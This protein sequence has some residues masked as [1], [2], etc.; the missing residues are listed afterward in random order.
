MV[1]SSETSASAYMPCT[2]AKAPPLKEMTV[3][4][5]SGVDRYETAVA[6]SRAGFNGPICFVYVAS[7][8]DFADALAGASRAAF[9]NTSPLLLVR[10]DHVPAAVRR[11][12]ARLDPVH[13]MV[14]GG[15][16]AISPAT[17]AQL[18]AIP[19]RGDVVLIDGP[20][21]YATAVAMAGVETRKPMFLASGQ[22]FP[23]ALSAASMVGASYG[24]LLLTPQ[25]ALPSV[26][27]HAVVEK[28]P[29]SITVLG[30][31]GAVSD[32]VVRDL[33][34][35]SGRTVSRIAGADRYET[36]VAVSRAY[37]SFTERVYI[38]SGATF[39]DALGVAP[40]ARLSRSAVL[41]VEPNRIPPSVKKE[42]ERLSPTHI[43]IVG[44]TGAVS[45]SVERE[46]RGYV[47]PL[48]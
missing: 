1:V 41:L 45:A 33:R 21:R 16:G 44:G 8:E 38:V 31:P 10:K 37:D 32:S 19:G 9:A 17:R 11:E 46:L 7:G 48:D 18:D 26:V 47:R 6:A 2:N 28:R 20:D 40:L 39:P 4:R 5:I 34:S 35:L 13:I 22:T 3:E 23:D 30:G 43:V 25:H 36:A 27:R 42:L 12:I 14:L 29:S 15:N 24:T